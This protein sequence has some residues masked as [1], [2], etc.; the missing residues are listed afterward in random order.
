M[1]WVEAGRRRDTTAKSRADAIGK[2]GELVD[3]LSAGT[4]TALGSS[5]GSALVAASGSG[6]AAGARAGMVGPAREEQESY[7]GG[8]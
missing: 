3:R 7:A 2:A 4:P 6:P 8:S 5:R 1:R